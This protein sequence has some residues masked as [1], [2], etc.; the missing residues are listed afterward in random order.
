MTS[1]RHLFQA[2][3]GTAIAQVDTKRGQAF[4]LVYSAS[5]GYIIFSND[6]HCHFFCFTAKY[7]ILRLIFP[8]FSP[9]KQKLNP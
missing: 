3:G 8:P 5:C 2:L 6:I 9:K 7:I 4:P 1:S